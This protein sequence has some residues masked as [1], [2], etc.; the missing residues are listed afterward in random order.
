[1]TAVTF[2]PGEEEAVPPSRSRRGFMLPA[3][4]PK[5]GER[6]TAPPARK[7][8]ASSAHGS[9]LLRPPLPRKAPVW[10]LSGRMG[11]LCAARLQRAARTAPEARTKARR[12]PTL[13]RTWGQL[14]RRTTPSRGPEKTRSASAIP[15]AGRQG[16]PPFRRPQS[17]ADSCSL[18]LPPKLGERETAPTQG[19]GLC[20]RASVS[21]LSAV[22]GERKLRLPFFPRSARP[23]F[24]GLRVPPFPVAADRFFAV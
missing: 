10:R 20:R 7:A 22:P 1:M 3:L 21:R 15:A 17:A 6:E 9:G 8:P 16:S 5:F 13:M 18:S 19:S 2:L 14:P 23:A 4:P 24:H 11:T 12:R